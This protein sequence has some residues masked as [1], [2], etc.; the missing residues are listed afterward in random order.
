MTKRDLMLRIS[1]ESGL[2]LEQVVNVVQLTLDKIAQAV[3]Q[4]HKLEIRNFGVFEVRLRKARTGRNPNAPT[5]DV[6]IPE[7]AVVKFKAGKDLREAVLKLTSK[8]ITAARA[9]DENSPKHNG[10]PR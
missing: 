10:R 3:A 5:V 6:S 4:G 2:E 8:E 7:R 1:E 9:L